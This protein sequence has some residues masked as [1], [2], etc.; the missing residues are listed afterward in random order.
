[1][2]RACGGVEDGMEIGSGQESFRYTLFIEIADFRSTPTA[3]SV[4]MPLSRLWKMGKGEG[5]GGRFTFMSCTTPLR[6]RDDG[7]RIDKISRR[8]G[9]I[10]WI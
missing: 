7:Y 5:E 1:M 2:V 9:Y 10:V 6:L 3:A 4:S 8:V